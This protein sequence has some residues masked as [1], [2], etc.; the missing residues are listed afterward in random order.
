[1]LLQADGLCAWLIYF[2]LVY[3]PTLWDCFGTSH[4]AV[5]P[6]DINDKLDFC[7][8]HY[9]FFSPLDSLG[10]TN[11]AL[12]FTL[13]AWLFPGL[14]IHVV[15]LFFVVFFYRFLHKIDSSSV[16]GRGIACLGG[17]SDSNRQGLYMML[18]P[19]NESNEKIILRWIQKSHFPVLACPSQHIYAIFKWHDIYSEHIY[20]NLF[21]FLLDVAWNVSLHR[22]TRRVCVA[23]RNFNTSCCQWPLDFVRGHWLCT[24][25]CGKEMSFIFYP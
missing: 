22:Y 8:H 23:T 6:Y 13:L 7:A 25:W 10:H 15:F 11:P 9:I 16:G 24:T 5:S 14:A 2:F 4:G 17:V 12:I 3:I 19:P 1:M 20:N 18:C 21:L